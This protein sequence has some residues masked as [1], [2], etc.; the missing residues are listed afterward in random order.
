M[1]PPSSTSR[2]DEDYFR[3]Y[4]EDPTTRVQ[5]PDEVGRLARAVC[6]F[7]AYWGMSLSDALDI[8]A[9]PGFWREAL[10][11]EV[12]DLKYTG[13]DVSPVACQR[14]G[15]QQRDISAWRDRNRYDL[16]ICQG[17]LQYIDDDQ[18]AAAIENIGAM[19]SGLLYIEVL[20]RRDVQQ[21][22]DLEK[23]D[24]NVHLRTGAW[25]RQHFKKDFIN[26]GC[27]LLCA[28]RAGALFYE[29]ESLGVLAVGGQDA[30]WTGEGRPQPLASSSPREIPGQGAQPEPSHPPAGAS[31]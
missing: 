19:A 23:S 29:M 26:V 11:R 4:Y 27:G 1:A 25:Y 9:G 13:V 18:A 8:G 5:G 16:I 7:A 2:F 22:A 3:R 31:L 28:R 15:H 30:G 20:T 17:V 10:R 12:P 21:V 24:T 6:A 14:Y